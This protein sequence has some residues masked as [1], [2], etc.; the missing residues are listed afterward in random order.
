MVCMI[1]VSVLCLSILPPHF[2]AQRPP[3]NNGKSE[4]ISKPQR[5]RSSCRPCTRSQQWGSFGRKPTVET[6][7]A[8]EEAEDAGWWVRNN[9]LC[10]L[11][12][13]HWFVVRCHNKLGSDVPFLWG[14]DVDL[15]IPRVLSRR[16]LATRA[17]LSTWVANA[18]CNLYWLE[19]VQFWSPPITITAGLFLM[20]DTFGSIWLVMSCNWHMCCIF[21][22]L[23]TEHMI[24]HIPSSIQSHLQTLQQP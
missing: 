5:Q 20:T 4:T 16:L 14:N 10:V 24:F 23:F 12:L 19:M 13:E 18:L 8:E 3:V 11:W 9:M 1:H 15:T 22:D 17:R 21:S 2:S 6:G 7:G